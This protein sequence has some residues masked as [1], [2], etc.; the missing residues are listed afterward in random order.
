MWIKIMQSYNQLDGYKRAQLEV[1]KKQKISQT[2]IA[3][4][5]GVN[6]STI[7]RELRRNKG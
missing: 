6:Q 5:L 2:E 7:S 4:E 3:L 1:L